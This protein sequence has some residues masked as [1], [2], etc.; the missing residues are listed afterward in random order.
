M[1]TSALPICAQCAHHAP[2]QGWN[3]TGVTA[4]T[5]ECRHP[6]AQIDTDPITGK[7]TYWICEWMRS[8]QGA[9]GAEGR[10][11]TQAELGTDT[12]LEEFA[13]RGERP[14]R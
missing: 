9:C 8:T 10:L 14:G 12:S 11:F 2:Q 6:S 5:L 4:D 13:Q 7:G 3:G 1:Q